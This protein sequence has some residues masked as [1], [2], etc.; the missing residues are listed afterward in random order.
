MLRQEV[1][2][3]NADT[4]LVNHDD[5]VVNFDFRCYPQLALFAEQEGKGS[6]VTDPDRVEKITGATYKKYEGK[7]SLPVGAERDSAAH[8]QMLLPE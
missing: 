2:R 7:D 6:G 8:G 4:V 5:P 1:E 3:A